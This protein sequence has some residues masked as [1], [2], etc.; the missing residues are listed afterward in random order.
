[1][2]SDSNFSYILGLDLGTSS[3]GWGLIRTQPAPRDVL[4]AGV[5]IFPEGMDRTRGEKSLNQDRRLSRSLR[6]Q[7]CRRAR[8][9]AK[10]LHALQEI[11]LLPA[12]ESQL[13]LLLQN[14]DPYKLR[15]LALDEKLE[16]WQVGRALYH[17]GQRRGY[18]SNRKTGSDKDGKV[19]AGISGLQNNIDA[20]NCRTL[21]EYFHKVDPH[22]ERI[23]GHYTSRAQYEHEFEL[24]W[25]T[26]ARYHPAVLDIANKKRIKE[27]IFFQRPLKTQKF[28]VGG[29]EFEPGR[30]RAQ[31]GSLAAQEFRLW[32]TINNLKILYSDGSE[33]YLTD[34]ERVSLHDELQARKNLSWAGVRTLLGL[35]ESTRFNLE[36]VRK[37]GLQG[38]ITAATISSVLGKKTWK[39]LG[40][41]GQEQLVAD[42]LNIENE[43]ALRNR[44]RRAYGVDSDKEDKLI[45]K[46]LGLPKGYLHVSAKAARKIA[47]ELARTGHDNGRGLTYDQACSAAG[48]I[49][50]KPLE[51]GNR[52]LLPFPG[53]PARDK[54]DRTVEHD[55]LVAN[56]LVTVDNLRNPLVERAIYQLRRVVNAIIK[57]YG[58]PALIRIELARDL[59]SSKKQREN[60]EKQ[61]KINEEAN[62]RAAKALVDYGI[63]NPSRSDLLKYRLWEECGRTCPYTG[64]SI[65]QDALFGD[66]PQFDVEHIIPYTRCLDDSYMNKTLCYRPENEAK[67]NLTPWEFYHQNEKS[68]EA[69]LQRAKKL[70]YPKF[71]RF[72]RDA[73]KDL[74]EFVSQ[75]LNETR[76]ISRKAVEYLSQLDGVRIETVKGGTTAL[77]RRAWGLNNIL[78]AGGE[79]TRMD[80][81]HHA[82]DAI[83]CAL[84]DRAAVQKISRYSAMSQ[85]RLRISGY[86]EPIKDIRIKVENILNKVLVSHKT[87][88]KVSGPLHD[89]TLYGKGLNEEGESRAVIRKKISEL[90]EKDILGEGRSIIRDPAIRR[91]ARAHLKKHGTFKNAFQ[92]KDNPF[93]RTT[94]SGK[95][96]P[97][98]RV[99]VLTDRS[100]VPIGKPGKKGRSGTLRY[101]WTRNNHHMEIFEVRK[102]SGETVWDARVISV[103]EA[104]R[105]LQRGEPLVRRDHG[106]DK[107]LVMVLHQN[108]MVKLS[109]NGEEVLCRVEKM[110]QNR[111]IVF[112][113]HQDADKD[114]RSSIKKRPETLRQANPRKI[115]VNVLG[116][117]IQESAV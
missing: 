47:A 1:M 79:K 17:L 11:G 46:S 78:D 97:I 81:R 92:N 70:P 85:G 38:N 107:K 51:K 108:D 95:F 96:I 56:S 13:K 4:A 45:A 100:V 106:K 93:G 113:R 88:R 111:N 6:R 114:W 98:N 32:Q 60:Y 77:L 22:Q 87:L 39:A 99:R 103:L 90:N 31:K 84:T 44:L 117:I 16:P 14:E 27:A 59:K 2:A 48:Y 15:A 86:P 43:S 18:L 69:V 63:P 104:M 54:R 72:A 66:H 82:V 68:Y 101:V 8:R 58:K 75:Q 28:L 83:V 9:K 57:K 33:R 110:D 61:Q 91:L 25:A 19:A 109:H 55:P 5:R 67:G 64:K 71:K 23:R 29:C 37:S 50:T 35:L 94:R 20:A 73:L 115:E 12:D 21:G 74:D 40:S 3:I 53:R 34:E 7:I 36:R 76:Y 105:R 65:S 80:H 26:Q 52:N 41:Q 42:L 89:D 30:K 116:E 49:H 10:L 24:I 112:R 62:K 102:P